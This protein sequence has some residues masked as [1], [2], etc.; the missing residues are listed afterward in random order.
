MDVGSALSFNV[1]LW[2]ERIETG[3]KE[4]PVALTTQKHRSKHQDSNGTKRAGEGNWAFPKKWR[5][6]V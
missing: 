4:K 3:E 1:V 2:I 6:D 5:D